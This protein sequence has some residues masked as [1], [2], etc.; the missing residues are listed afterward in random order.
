MESLADRYSPE[1]TFA[2]STNPFFKLGAYPEIKVALPYEH[3]YE[4]LVA[5]GNYGIQNED[6]YCE[7][8]DYY[9]LANPE[10]IFEKMNFFSDF[11]EDS[12]VRRDV[13]RE[14]GED[15]KPEIS[16][17]TPVSIEVKYM[18]NVQAHL[19]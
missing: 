13:I 19:F 9:N 6:D 15:T 2:R 5:Q 10:N 14:I 1:Q 12:V 16:K 7:R 11:A 17:Y 18:L 3:G 4:Q 8:V